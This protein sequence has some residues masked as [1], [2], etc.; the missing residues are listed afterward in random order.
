MTTRRDFLGGA[1][2]LAALGTAGCR[3]GGKAVAAR[4]AAGGGAWYK[5]MLHCH[6]A[7]S[8]GHA[9]PEQALANYR[10]AGYNFCALTDHNRTVFDAGNWRYV[11]REVGGWPYSIVPAQV[12]NAR[13]RFPDTVKVRDLPDGTQMVR[14]TPL[15]E[16]RRAFNEPNRFLV[17]GGVEVTRHLQTPKVNAA[18]HMNYVNL[19]GLIES[20]RDRNMIETYRGEDWD[21][22][23]LIR[24]TRE[25]VARYAERLG[26]PPHLFMVNHPLAG[27]Y[28][29]L[30]EHIIEDETIRFVE[31]H[32]GG[33]K[34]VPSAPLDCKGYELDRYWD[35]INAFRARKGAPLVY[36]VASDDTHTYPNIGLPEPEIQPEFAHSCV[37]VRADELTEAALFGAMARGDFYAMAGTPSVEDVSF[38][39]GALRVRAAAR[40]GETLTVSFVVSK[41][42]FDPSFVEVDSGVRCSLVPNDTKRTVRHYPDPRIGQVVRTVTGRPGE[43]VDASY[44]LAADD[45]YVRARIESDRPNLEAKLGRTVFTPRGETAWTQPYSNI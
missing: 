23:R 42:G 39:K 37:M 35:I 3:T 40:P 34:S 14:I 15:D 29:V 6:T 38:G 20:C 22:R 41:K 2:L 31:I 19:D 16:L 18:V 26:N 13:R 21:V 4:P 43:A 27:V 10:D 17:L 9:L 25:E 12:E 7:L 33:A 8:D 30:P 28:S 36:G 1:A 11:K 44:A 45:L 24:E 32:N 5:G